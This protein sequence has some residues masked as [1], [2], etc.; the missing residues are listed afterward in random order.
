MGC[1]SQHI[2]RELLS[3]L[4]L[5]GLRSELHCLRRSALVSQWSRRSGA[6]SCACNAGRRRRLQRGDCAE[7]WLSIWTPLSPPAPLRTACHGGAVDRCSCHRAHVASFAALYALAAA[8][9]TCSAADPAQ[10]SMRL[11]RSRRP[12]LVL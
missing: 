2:Q 9:D 8:A 5:R 11:R 6:P 1:S 7:P 3:A 12:A 10:G 4:L